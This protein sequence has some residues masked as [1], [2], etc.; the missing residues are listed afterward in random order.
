MK[1]VLRNY[2]YE[3]KEILKQHP[4]HLL[5]DDMGLGKTLTALASVLER[6][7]AYPILIMAPL[8]ALGVWRYELKKWFDHPS[9][10]YHGKPAERQQMLTEI[11]KAERPIVI[12]TYKAIDELQA[13]KPVWGTIIA[14]EVHRAGLLNRKSDTFKKFKKFQSI[15]L[16]LMTGT[17]FRQTPADLWPL[18]HLV[19]PKTFKSYW[20][21][22][23]KYCLQTDNGFGPVIEKRPK[24][25]DVFRQVVRTYMIRRRKKDVLTELPPLQRIPIPLEMTEKQ[26]SFYNAMRD[27]F[28]VEHGDQILIALNRLSRDLRL[29]Q[30]LVSPRLL[31][32]SD[33]GAA[34]KAVLEMIEDEYEAGNSVAV[35]TPFRAAVELFAER[36][37]MI[38]SYVGVIMGQSKRPASDIAEEFQ[39]HPNH[40]KAIVGTID[41]G[42]A[43][44]IHDASVMFIV[45]PDWD[46]NDNEQA[47]ARIH[48]LG[49]TKAVRIYYPLY[50]VEMSTRVMEVLDEKVSGRH[51][52][53]EE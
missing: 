19:A 8:N 33:D 45:G 22:V 9:F 13:F 42:T 52:S 51:L 2:Q 29:R 32:M 31:G 46:A 16:I 15:R 20:D 39:L 18:L 30:M 21:F 44:T 24:N 48:R 5:C 6:G 26:A 40:R 53:I 41:S 25:P 36:L 38:S 50:D 17:P 4:K 10:V 14:D 23:E 34:L 12:A 49:Q 3:A 27:T 7:T 43:Y 37:K 28:M 1:I 11:R 35:Y 47:E